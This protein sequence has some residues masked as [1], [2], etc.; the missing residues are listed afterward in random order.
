V[1]DEQICQQQ[2]DTG[3]NFIYILDQHQKLYI[4]P[5]LPSQ[6]TYLDCHSEVE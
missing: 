6:M 5:C 2:A 4:A 3:L 1:V